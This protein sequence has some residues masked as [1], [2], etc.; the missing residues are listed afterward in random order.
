M[1]LSVVIPCYNEAGNIPL[2]I[3]RFKEV[4]PTDMDCEVLLVNNGST[5]NSAE[6]FVKELTAIG[7]TR[8]K[9]VEVSKNQ[10]YGFGILSGLA[11]AQGDVMAWTHADMQTDPKDVVRAFETYVKHNDPLLFVKGKRRSRDFVPLLFT[12]GMGCVA[13]WA[14]GEKLY[15]IGAQP[16][17]FSRLFYSAHLQKN[18]PWDFSLDLFAQ[19]WAQRSGK[20]IEIP[21]YFTKRFHGEA[22][23]GGSIKTRL[24]VTRRVFSYILEL[25]R[26]LKKDK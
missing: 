5:D 15:D 24:K 14:L 23:G 26:G 17:L 7:D 8:F 13:S 22:K 12:W 2:I 4:L 19:Y 10:G 16:K 20:I 18:A 11:N 9:V 1:K 3:N 25:R 21:V 6:I